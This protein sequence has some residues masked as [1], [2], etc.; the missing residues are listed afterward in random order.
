MLA[1][2]PWG[3][4]S[5]CGADPATTGRDH[6]E[7]GL[8]YY[9]ARYYDASTGRFL[10]EDPLRFFSDI[11]FYRYVFNSPMN[12]IDPFGFDCT[13]TFH[14]G[15]G[16]IRCVDNQS[17]KVVAD[18]TGYS[19]NGPGLNNPGMQGTEDTGPLPQGS[20]SIGAPTKR[21]GPLTLP[22]TPLPGTNLQGRPGGFLIH[23]DNKQNNHSASHGCIIQSRNVRQ[24][25]SNCGGGTV[26]V[27][28]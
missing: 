10:S 21:K 25:I 24:A 8:S 26:N 19:G 3:F 11:N 6:S 20:Y 18:G 4:L 16:A 13:C 7:S 23:G 27:E 17:G 2:R 22:L 14:Q 1:Y 28:Q 9:R 15:T 5:N 12:F